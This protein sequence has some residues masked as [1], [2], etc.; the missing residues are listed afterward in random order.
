MRKL[1]ISVLATALA[2]TA[3]SIVGS[4]V[5]AAPVP[6]QQQAATPA[7][8]AFTVGMLLQIKLSVA[9]SWL[10]NLPAST[11]VVIDTAKSGE[12]VIVASPTPQF[13]GVQW[14]WAIRRG[15]GSVT[16]WVEEQ[17]L[18]PAVNPTA[19][20]SLAATIPPTV[21]AALPIMTVT[22]AT[23]PLSG[24]ILP[25]GTAV[26]LSNGLP[27]VWLR[28]S[29]SSGAPVR[30]VVYQH[31]QLNIR[32]ATPVSDGTQ[33]WS[34]VNYPLLNLYGWVEQKS[35]VPA[36]IP[37]A[38]AMPIVPPPAMIP[39]TPTTVP[40]AVSPTSYAQWGVPGIVRIRKSVAYS[41]LRTV[42]GGAIAQTL[43]S[44][45]VVLLKDAPVFDGVQFWWPVQ[46][47]A[48]QTGWI[49]Q[50]SLELVAAFGPVPSGNAM[51]VTLPSGTTSNALPAATMVPADNS[52]LTTPGAVA[53]AVMPTDAPSPT[54]TASS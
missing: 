27:F 42:P 7:P 16:G 40:T 31:A 11:A 3:S 29:P 32:D 34:L 18:Q 52:A 46:T 25:V 30:V 9:Y 47:T 51:S 4:T 12:F 43:L 37:A 44:G 33:L 22:P 20:A 26:T 53:P 6:V 19:T 13:D 41:W 21:P 1:R 2:V 17:A 14:W 23:A 45:S 54:A 39:N 48:S 49:E 38:A 5:Q 50:K 35:L 8:A 28:S 24:N 10:R 36:G 15:S